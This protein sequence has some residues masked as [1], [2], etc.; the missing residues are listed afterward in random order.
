MIK[1]KRHLAAVWILAFI[2]IIGFDLF[3]HAGVLNRLYLNSGS[4]LLSS[5]EAF[6][7]IPAGYLSFAIFETLVLWLMFK[8]E[9]QGWKAGLAFGLIFGALVWG[10]LVLGLFSISTASPA[11]LLGWFLGQTAESGIGGMV[12][13]AGLWNERLRPL[14]FKVLIFFLIMVTLGIV[15]QNL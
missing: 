5:E 11:L 13:G 6:R 12:I 9:I 15:I 10:S 4:F 7:R 3:L 1:S 8:L 2:A 14:L